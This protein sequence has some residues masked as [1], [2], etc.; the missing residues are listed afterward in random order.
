MAKIEQLN[1]QQHKNIRITKNTNVAD[2]KKQN[3]LPVVLAEFPAAALAF[4]ICFIKRPDS[5]E[6]QTVALL[7]VEAGENLFVVDDKWD[8]AYIPA[9][10]THTPFGL[11]RNPEDEAQFA[12]AIDVENSLVSETEGERLFDDNG[13][14]TEY[15]TKQKEAMSNYVEQE[16]ITKTFVRILDEHEL[17]TTRAINVNVGEKKMTID[18]I[19]M[20]DEEKIKGLSDELVLEFHKKGILPSVYAHLLSMRQMNE[21]VRRKATRLAGQ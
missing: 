13:E 18:G 15:L 21:L 10:Y 2:L 5:D 12:L 20:V 19:T 8:A 6:Y 11:F 3:I 16:H 7:G 1:N 4:P 9:R 17:L 14:A